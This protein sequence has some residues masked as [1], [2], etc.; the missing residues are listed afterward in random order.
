MLQVCEVRHQDRYKTMKEENNMFLEG[1]DNKL[2]PLLITLRNI[3][4]LPFN[5]LSA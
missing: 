4:A 3:R 1:A 5:K 2:R